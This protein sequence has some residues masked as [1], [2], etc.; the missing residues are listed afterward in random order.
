MLS[1]FIFSFPD[2][3]KPNIQSMLPEQLQTA[4]GRQV[5]KLDDQLPL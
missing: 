5:H 2:K 4:H 3:P 1:Y